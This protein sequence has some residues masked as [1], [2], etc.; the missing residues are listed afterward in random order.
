MARMND[1]I[2]K[3]EYLDATAFVTVIRDP[4]PHHSL[5]PDYANPTRFFF[6]FPG[7]SC[8]VSPPIGCPF[9]TLFLS[10]AS[11][12]SAA[13]ASRYMISDIPG[14]SYHFTRPDWVIHV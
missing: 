2:S 14:M 10:L 6:G 12:T 4:G 5:T 7:A 11:L 3:I 1:C 9:L 13:F 8:C